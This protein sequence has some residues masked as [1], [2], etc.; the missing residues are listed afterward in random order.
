MRTKNEAG[1]RIIELR[2]DGWRQQV[3]CIADHIR[4]LSSSRSRY[5]GVKQEEGGW[6]TQHSYSFSDIAILVRTNWVARLV[7]KELKI[8]KVPVAWLAR[9]NE[10]T[11]SQEEEEAQ[12]QNDDGPQDGVHVLTVHKAKGLEWPVVFVVS[13]SEGNMPMTTTPDVNSAESLVHRVFHGGCGEMEDDGGALDAD[14]DFDA[15]ESGCDAGQRGVSHCI[16]GCHS[17]SAAVVSVSQ[18]RGRQ[19]HTSVPRPAI[20]PSYRRSWCVCRTSVQSPSR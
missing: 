4:A 18:P 7:R 11:A 12:W 3:H 6:S 2:T 20:C 14:V 19:G 15:A 8:A 10:L 16:R 5:S 13:F 9:N 17:C 1:E